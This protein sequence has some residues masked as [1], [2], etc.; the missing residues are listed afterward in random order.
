[1][2]KPAE[3]RTVSQVLNSSVT[4]VES[5]FVPAADAM[6]EDKYSFAPTSGEFK[7]V[8]TFGQQIKHVAAVNYI[9]GGAILGEKPPVDTGGENGPDSVKSKADIMKYLK[10]SFVYL[11]KATESVERQKPGCAHQESLRRRHRDPSGPRSWRRRTLLRPLR[12]DGGIPAYERHCS[13]R[14]PS[15]GYFCPTGPL[16]RGPVWPAHGQL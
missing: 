4:N 11:H 12:T 10:D 9:L 13:A 15:I 14:Q 6:P 8:R 7:G 16:V 2:E 1:M 5:E 3:N